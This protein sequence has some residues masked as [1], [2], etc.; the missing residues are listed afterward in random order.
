MAT[1]NNSPAANVIRRVWFI[2]TLLA[3]VGFSVSGL[4]QLTE[5]YT[6]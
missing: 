2:G 6:A 3:I 1:A 4:T 5:L